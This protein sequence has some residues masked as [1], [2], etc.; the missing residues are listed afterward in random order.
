MGNPGVWV[1]ELAQDLNVAA[2]GDNGDDVA[3]G[4]GD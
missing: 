3:D 2:D 4:D 1:G